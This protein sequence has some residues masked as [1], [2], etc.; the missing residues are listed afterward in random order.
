M[1]EFREVQS[2]D[3]IPSDIESPYQLEIMT[4]FGDYFLRM[5][6]TNFE[7]FFPHMRYRSDIGGGSL[8]LINY[9]L[10]QIYKS[11][12]GFD[13]Q[14]S[15]GVRVD[16]VVDRIPKWMDLTVE[17]GRSKR[18]PKYSIFDIPDDDVYPP[19]AF[20]DIV[21]QQDGAVNLIQRTNKP[22]QQA[23]ITFLPDGKYPVVVAAFTNIAERIAKAK[24]SRRR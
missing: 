20:I 13:E 12:A 23:Q 21:V 5:V 10:S 8:S 7:M 18:Q 3:P 22:I 4:G 17:V 1:S 15:S 9:E 19:S 6:D 11:V 2:L 24:T 16:E 14:V